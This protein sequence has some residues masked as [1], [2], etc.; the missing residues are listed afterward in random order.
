MTVPDYQSLMLP[1]LKT[2]SNQEELKTRELVEKLSSE[3]NLSDEDKK[4]LLPSG[5]QPVMDNRVG[6]AKTYLQKAGLLISEKRGFIKISQKG[7]EVL[8]QNHEKIN[9]KFLEQ[10]PEFIEFRTVKKTPKETPIQNENLENINP[11]ELIEE[12]YKSINDDLI[13]DLLKQLRS[14]NPYEFEKIIGKLL[15]AMGYGEFEETPKSNDGGIDGIVNQDK[16]GL[17]KIF[18][19]AKRYAENNPVTASNVRD[20]VGTLAL[21]KVQKGIFITTS[22]FPKGTE[23]IL[24]KAQKTIILIDGFKL[25][26]LM[27]EYNLGVNVIETYQ[28]K[29]LDL[30][31]FS[32]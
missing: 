18:F 31:F 25:A 28:I 19:Q 11:I 16:L 4:E 29:E 17:D 3:F 13:A 2:L 10:F 22:K 30:D 14:I 12:G 1:V 15:S 20:F 27:I 26:K 5:K 24:E 23:A 6:W 9:V 7:L 21:N 8:K 32:E